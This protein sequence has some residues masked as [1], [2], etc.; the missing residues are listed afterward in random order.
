ME[1]HRLFSCAPGGTEPY[2]FF[3]YGIIQLLALPAFDTRFKERSNDA[4][5]RFST[6]ASAFLC[7]FVSAVFDI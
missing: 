4:V 3:R 5:R 2:I 1:R 6:R 7:S